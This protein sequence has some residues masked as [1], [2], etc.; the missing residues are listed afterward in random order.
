MGYKY[1]GDALLGV[2]LTVNTPKPLDS[3]SVVDNLSQLYSIP[4]NT[5]YQGMTVANIA[6][7][8]I[9][10]LVDKSKINEKA[11]WKASYESIQIITCTEAEYKLWQENTNE[12]FTPKD[13]TQTYLHSDT[14]YYIFEDSLTPETEGQQYLTRSW[15]EDVEE[16]LSSKASNDSVIKLNQEVSGINLNLENN[17]LTK[18]HIIQTFA[19]KALL[20][21]TFN[22]EL[23]KYYTKEETDSIFVTKDALRGGI[24]GS[25][26]F[27]F[28]TQSKYTEDQ[29]IIQEQLDNTLKTNGEGQLESIT[30]KTIKSPDETPLVVTLKEEG[31]FVNDS[32]LARKQE[33][34]KLVTLSQSEY[35]SKVEEQLD[36]DT[37]YYI[38]DTNEDLAYITNEYLKNNYHT[39]SQYQQ[40]IAENYY[41]KNHINANYYSKEEVSN[42]ITDLEN[43]ISKLTERI[44]ALEQVSGIEDGGDTQENPTEEPIE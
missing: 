6:N 15:G 26:D 40:I 18:D 8:N 34:P 19:T 3:R 24:E 30:V 27:I 39:I 31:I 12:D 22:T 16:T 13:E 14:Y 4:E 41:Q 32:I 36:E 17:Y 23:Q 43:K 9:Y 1:T 20:E 38:Y 35:D 37:Y 25:D 5:A 21:E 42:I 10:M 2:S 11:G 33:V 44:N 28:V 29:A 7:G